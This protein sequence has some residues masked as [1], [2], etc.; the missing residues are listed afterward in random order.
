MATRRIST[1]LAVDGEA[2]FKQ[3]ITSCNSTLALLKSSLAATESEFRNSANTLNA[4]EE[5][6]KKFNELKAEQEKKINNLEAA[7]KNCQDAVDS[8][9]KEHDKLQP[10]VK[11]SNQAIKDL[12]ATTKSAGKQWANYADEIELSQKKLAALKGMSKDTS[13]AQARLQADIAK[14]REEMEKLEASTGGAAKRAGEMILEN[15][16]LNDSFDSNEAKLNAAVR[17]ANNWEKQLNNARIAS[18]QLA[19]E[20]A[21]NDQ[22]LAE[23]RASA[24]KCATSIDQYGKE[25]KQTAK[26]VEEVTEATEE[27][28]EA[29]E[30]FGDK[31]KA[32]M[33]ALA[34]AIVAAGIAKGVKEIAESLLDCSEAAAEFEGTVAKI[35]T[36]ADTNAVP[37]DKIRSQVLALSGD[38]GKAAAS[39]S[40]AVYQAIS[41]SVETSQAAEAVGKASKLAVG[42]FTSVATSVDV[43]TSALNAY[44]LKASETEKIS[45]ILITTQK[46]GKTTVDELAQSVGKVIP[47][48]A[49]YNVQMDNLGTSYAILTANGIATAEAGTYLKSMIN[50]LGDSGSK[51]AGILREKTGKSFADLTKSGRSMGDVLDILGDSVGGSA[52]AFNELWSST[53]AGIG[54]LSIFNSGA[55]HFNSVLDEMQNSA[56]ATEAA[57]QK[58][59]DTTEFA[60]QRMANASDNL[61]IAIGEQLNPALKELYNTGADAFTWAAD[62]V[63]ANPEIVGATAA[64]T[65]GIGALTVG[66]TLAANASRIAAAK[67]AVLNAVMG[68]NPAS[69]LTAALTALVAAITAYSLTVERADAEARS[70]V[71]SLRESKDAYDALSKS[72]AAEQSSVTDSVRALQKLLEVEDKSTAQKDQI[73]QMVEA[74][75]QA[76]PDLG[77]AYDAASDSI[78]LTSD[79]LE[80]MAEA[81]REQE[82]YEAQV[83]RLNELFMERESITRELEDAQTR[84][85]EA[86]ANAQWDS[87]GGAM[88]EAAV[89]VEQ[90]RGGVESLTAAQADNAAQI[91]ALEE[92]TTTY[93]LRQVEASA[94]SDDMAAK[95]E[96]MTA[97]MESLAGE[98][99]TLKAAYDESYASAMDSINQQIGLFNELDGTAKTSIDSLIE[100]LKGQIEY[101]ETYAD[102]IQKAMEMGVDD[103]LIRKLS[104]GSERSAQILASIVK[105]GEEDIRSLN[106]EFAKVEKGKEEFSGTVAEMEAD[107]KKKMGDIEKDLKDSIKKMDLK[108][109]TYKIGS[110]NMQGLINGTASQKRALIEKYAEMG[111]AALAA[112]KKEV[113]QA[114]P[115][116]AFYQAG[117]F[118]IQGIIR[119]AESE[120]AKL[121]EAYAGMARTA[122]RSMERGLPATFVEPKAVNQRDQTAAIVEAVRNSNAGGSTALSAADIAAAV[123]DALSGMSVNMNRRK[124]GELVDEWQQNNTRS[125]GD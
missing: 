92:A 107:F 91:A 97:R 77:L 22:Y 115:S 47:L 89:N 6:E 86:M 96:A 95:T 64:V 105:G 54:A 123:R 88:N 41:S 69:L 85:D 80:R 35:S 34:Q 106:E 57:Y 116:K 112:Y 5:K 16:K 125:R 55:E 31:G 58:M 51:V 17:G 10:K 94:S 108:D 32:A 9:Q 39:V 43:L 44:K 90:L 26:E 46:K 98:L 101:M 62:F 45:D 122:L 49:A 63:A 38:S 74:L 70:L 21:K 2:E 111:R 18:N 23:A 24:D 56:G 119:G 113:R 59:A 68:A 1:K 11:E 71:S 66:L 82:E 121:D 42:G 79:A 84:L 104:D 36:I 118:D 76:V 103:G 14:A 78:N 81:Y 52:A 117:S 87:F 29:T 100:T 28:A 67:Q 124:V 73:L 75:N 25:V 50:E 61:R 12:D 33:E 37:I 83:D 109:D 40:E 102:N 30:D 15:W 72:M 65:S 27:A 13:T 4:L 48:A 120:R 53:E 93:A 20:I 7:L 19:D 110:N 60:H 3:A 99:E 8:Y 114:S